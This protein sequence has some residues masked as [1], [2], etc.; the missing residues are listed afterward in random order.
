MVLPGV[1]TPSRRVVLTLDTPSVQ[2]YR[3]EAERRGSERPQK[4]DNHFPRRFTWA[5]PSHFQQVRRRGFLFGETMEKQSEE[6]PLLA[7]TVEINAMSCVVFA[8][9]K[10][11]AKWI[12]VKGY[13]DAGYGRGR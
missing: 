9:T 8:A 13:W 6:K 11:K 12:A 1:Q 7:W 4:R 10:D 2:A 5:F 3:L